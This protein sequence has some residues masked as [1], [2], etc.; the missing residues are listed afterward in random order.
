M[1]TLDEIKQ[2]MHEAVDKAWEAL[3]G[4]H[5]MDEARKVAQETTA[6]LQDHVLA[7]EANLFNHV[8]D[9]AAEA[10]KA[11]STAAEPAP[12]EE[13]AKTEPT[14]TPEDPAPP[15]ADKTAAASGKKATTK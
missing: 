5:D 2:K 6:E 14:E 7:V 11:E 4:T 15:A 1:M 9:N 8:A 3:H 10:A 12:S 13:P